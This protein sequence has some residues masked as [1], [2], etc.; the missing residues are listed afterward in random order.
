MKS[1]YV[2]NI[3]FWPRASFKLGFIIAVLIVGLNIVGTGLAQNASPV[4]ISPSSSSGSQ[5]TFIATYTVPN[6]EMNV[7]SLS[8]F[9]MDG[10][11]LDSGSGWAANECILNYTIGSGLIQMVQDAGGAFL[12]NSAIAGTDQTVSNSQC[13]VLA[14]L[15]SVNISGNVVTVSFY[16]TFTAAFRG[17]KQLYLSVKNQRGDNNANFVT[18]VGT[19]NVTASVSSLFVSPAS[20]SGSEQTFTTVYSDETNPVKSVFFNLK[21][22]ANNTSA[23]NACKLRYDLATDDI[24]L[25]NDA[26]TRYSSPI[27]SGSTTLLSN[28]QC[29]VY[30][31]GTSATTFGNF[32]V[33]YFTVSFAAG[34]D[35]QKEMT[36]FGEDET[37]TFSFNNRSVGNYTVRAPPPTETPNFRLTNTAVSVA[38]VGVP[39][40]ST[41]TITPE[42]GFTESVALTCTVI[43]A[44]TAYPPTCV[45]A[46]PSTIPVAAETTATLIVNTTPASTAASDNSL[47]KIFV[48]GGSIIVAALF[49][50]LSLR[51]RWQTLLCLLALATIA[52]AAGCSAMDSRVIA[53]TSPG[54]PN[55]GTTAGDYIVAVTGTS[56]AVMA[57]TAVSVSVK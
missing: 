50:M 11:A 20:G 51:K 42:G 33:G 34:F 17:P 8:L 48:G 16:V 31:V 28:S 29:T 15:S 39:A 45:F 22:S 30:G 25:V 12:S 37:G 47:Q 3:I 19:Y 9:I 23:A 26:G 41:I 44:T 24:F 54:A 38:Q 43:G 2:L 6:S 21:S 52:G 32:V 55:P 1:H 57:T 10:I 46:A 53:P 5:Q 36:M 27:T 35:G 13:T 7:Q 49:P 14:N 56:G 40:I 18:Q 4:S